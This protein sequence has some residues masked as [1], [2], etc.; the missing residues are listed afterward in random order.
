MVGNDDIQESWK[1]LQKALDK[2]NESKYDFLLKNLLND[3]L[4]PTISVNKSSILISIQ[5][6]I[7]V[8][9]IHFRYL[10]PYADH[11]NSLASDPKF[12]SFQLLK[13]LLL[14]ASK[15][16]EL[17]I[18]KIFS[19]LINILK[20]KLG[21]QNI[22]KLFRT[23]A[24]DCIDVLK[25]KISKIEPF[26][27]E[28]NDCLQIASDDNLD[29]FINICKWNKGKYC[30]SGNINTIL[31]LLDRDIKSDDE[32]CTNI[33]SSL[34]LH[35]PTKKDVS[36]PNEEKEV[37]VLSERVNTP[38]I[39]DPP[40][41]FSKATTHVDLCSSSYSSS[42]GGSS[43]TGSGMIDILAPIN[44]QTTTTGNQYSTSVEEVKSKVKSEVKSQPV[45]IASEASTHSRST[46]ADIDLINTPSFDENST[47]STTK[48]DIHPSEPA[49][50][51]PSR[52]QSSVVKS[53]RFRHPISQERP[54]LKTEPAIVVDYQSSSNTDPFS[55]NKNLTDEMTDTVDRV[56]LN[57]VES[58]ERYSNPYIS[59]YR[60]RVSDNICIDTASFQ[61]SVQRQ[62]YRRRRKPLISPKGAILT[63]GGEVSVAVVEYS[64]SGIDA[65]ILELRAQLEK[66]NTNTCT[67]TDSN[68]NSRSYELKIGAV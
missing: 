30:R 6:I 48:I 60:S 33:W 52:N 14:F 17:F 27:E 65:E 62:L 47:A 43:C 36:K 21:D 32:L 22:I 10:L 38:E 51:R 3:L 64:L 42:D 45:D 56:T 16:T 55:D 11:I 25:D 8:Y 15:Q 4:Y 20:L 28:T 53:V 57:H 2:Q 18:T 7:N 46:S 13:L 59:A 19:Q 67:D 34:S 50:P 1:L 49:M 68:S 44:Y 12:L 63:T 37:V 40:L 41:V 54:F 61:V 39:V 31:V 26:S 35:D 66:L 24:L 5:T 23:R 9:K 29:A 58:D